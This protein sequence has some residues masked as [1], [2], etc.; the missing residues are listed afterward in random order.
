MQVSQVWSNVDKAGLMGHNNDD[1]NANLV[2]MGK[3]KFTLKEKFEL[4][5]IG[6]STKD[7]QDM[8]LCA[9]QV[10][11]QDFAGDA[12]KALTFMRDMNST[13]IAHLDFNDMVHQGAAHRLIALRESNPGEF[14]NVIKANYTN[15][16][17]L[18]TALGAPRQQA[19]LAPSTRFRP[20]TATV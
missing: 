6:V 13:N 12:K 15:V 5:V 20:Q 9:K 17:E 7:M 2:R 14:G 11:D 4:A 8:A 3:G 1:I 18:N 19:S 10:V 16:A